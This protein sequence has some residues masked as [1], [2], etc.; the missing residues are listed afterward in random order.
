[1]KKRFPKEDIL[2]RNKHKKRCSTSLVFREMQINTKFVIATENKKEIIVKI[3]AIEHSEKQYYSYIAGENVKWH[4]HY[5]K[6]FCQFI[7]I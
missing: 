4:C 7:T 2:L 5:G 6:Y 1:M 3:S